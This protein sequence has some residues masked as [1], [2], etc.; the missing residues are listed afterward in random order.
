MAKNDP[1]VRRRLVGGAAL[2]M[3]RRGVSR[4]SIREVAKFSGT[5][6][7]STY[8]YFPAGK[9]QLITE[10]VQMTGET[11]EKQLRRALLAGPEA[12]LQAFIEA[13]RNNVIQS[14]YQAGCPVLAVSV[15]E[16]EDEDGYAA[17]NVAADVFKIWTGLLASSLTEHGV[18]PEQA[19]QIATLA[20]ASLEGT[21]PMCRAQRSAAPLDHVEAQV[22]ALIRMALPS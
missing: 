22:I 19:E 1:E 4:T 20:V 21:V 6:L 13:W 15:D 17:L 9:K 7:G 14:D 5:P 3:S 10:A 18:K 16:P 2:M 8:H 11:I 12:G